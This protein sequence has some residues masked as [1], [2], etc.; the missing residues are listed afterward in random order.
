MFAKKATFR[1]ID[2]VRSIARVGPF[3]SNDNHAHRTARAALVCHWRIAP[4]TGK[5]ECHWRSDRVM[6]ARFGG[7]RKPRPPAPGEV[8]PC[9]RG[10]IS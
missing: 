9:R 1:A 10:K 2:R 5:P 8:H 4:A 7:E 3:H 6:P